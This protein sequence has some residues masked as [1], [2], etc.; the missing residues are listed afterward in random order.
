MTS[1][2]YHKS[3]REALQFRVRHIDG[4]TAALKSQARGG[5]R[6]IIPS[7]TLDKARRG[8]L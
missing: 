8:R 1:V 3:P 6:E 5:F 2:F 4:N 7:R